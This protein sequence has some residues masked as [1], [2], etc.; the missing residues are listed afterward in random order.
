MDVQTMPGGKK[1]FAFGTGQSAKYVA[2]ID[3]L[4]LPKEEE[5]ALGSGQSAKHAATMNAPTRH[6]KEGC[7]PG[8][9]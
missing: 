7:D 3:V 5:S 2:M 8:M 9:G 1:E 6:N 4:I